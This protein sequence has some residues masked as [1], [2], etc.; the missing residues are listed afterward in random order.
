MIAFA[1]EGPWK[2]K[3][4]EGRDTGSRDLTGV[5]RHTLDIEDQDD[6]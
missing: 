1:Q 5:G 3:G 4:C 2:H 6:S